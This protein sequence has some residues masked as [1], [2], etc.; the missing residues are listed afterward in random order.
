MTCACTFAVVVPL[1]PSQC[2]CICTA[3]A[4]AHNLHNGSSIVFKVGNSGSGTSSIGDSKSTTIFMRSNFQKKISNPCRHS[5]V[6]RLQGGQFEQWHDARRHRV[7]AS[8]HETFVNSHEALVY[9][10]PFIRCSRS[11]DACR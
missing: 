1:A 8:L 7:A 9:R 4:G 11:H 5:H 2:P 6:E 3:C 10:K